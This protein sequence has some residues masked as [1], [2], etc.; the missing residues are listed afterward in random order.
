MNVINPFKILIGIVLSS[1]LV[2]TVGPEISDGA[3][4]ATKAGNGPA[5]SIEFKRGDAWMNKK[6]MGMLNVRISPQFAIWAEDSVGTIATLFVTRAFGKQEWKM[7]K[8]HADSCGRPMC[9]PYW[10]NRLVAKGMQRPTK[11]HP[12]SDAITGATPKGSFMLN[13]TL[14]EGFNKF[15]LY[16]E[17]NKSFDN[18]EA[19]PA[20]GFSTFNGQPPVVYEASVNLADTTSK[21]WAL[22]IKG[23]SGEKGNDPTL[24]PIDK[25]L[26]TALEMVKSISVK[27]R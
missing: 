25:K 22:S 9:M 6:K 15:N 24:Y 12:L 2:C 27:R 18:N 21:T 7:M 14:P 5:I 1:L 3:I 10:L 26:T 17:I 4:V 16:V 19:W 11:N 8:F 13:T 23:M 20:K